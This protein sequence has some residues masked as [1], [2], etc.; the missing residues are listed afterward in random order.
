MTFSH[1]MKET[2]ALAATERVF[3][4]GL[5]MQISKNGT[6]ADSNVSSS[7]G[8]G[9]SRPRINKIGYKLGCIEILQNII[10]IALLKNIFTWQLKKK[11][12]LLE[13]LTA[14]LLF[15]LL[16]YIYSVILKL[17]LQL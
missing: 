10:Q 5:L 12:C 7:P 1:D 17:F 6:N 2:K 13:L 15:F 8:A 16:S 3:Q 4:I 14:S 11:K 9:K